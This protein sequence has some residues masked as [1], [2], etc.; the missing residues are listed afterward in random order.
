MFCGL[1]AIPVHGCPTSTNLNIKLEMFDPTVSSTA[2]TVSCSNQRCDFKSPVPRTA[3]SYHAIQ[4]NYTID[5]ST[6]RSGGLT[7]QK[8]AVDGIFGFGQQGLSVV[9]QLSSKAITPD[10]FSHCLKG[11]DS[12]GV[13][14]TSSNE[15]TIIDSGTSLAR[16]EE[17]VYKPL[18]NAI[19]QAV[20]ESVRPFN[21]KGLQCYII[22]VAVSDVF[23]LATL[24]FAGGAS[25]IL[26]PED[27]L[28]QQ[29]SIDGALARCLGFQKSKQRAFTVLGGTCAD[30]DEMTGL[31]N[32]FTDIVLKDKIVVYDLGGQRIGWADYDCDST[33]GKALVVDE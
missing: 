20:S 8:G 18:V 11:G 28:W 25:R 12:G 32:Y 30:L 1:V 23:P 19:T 7:K 33:D 15:Q 10:S 22:H 2:S 31:R 4:C 16:L 13:H 14:S 27:Y 17:E 29:I 21:Y 26:A 5:C 3:C 24:Y 9:S 6:S